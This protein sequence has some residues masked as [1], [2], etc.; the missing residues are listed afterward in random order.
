MKFFVDTGSVEDAK[1]AMATGYCD[2]VTT[3][4]SLISKG[5]SRPLEIIVKEITEIVHG[6]TSVEVIAEDAVKMI[7]EG[8]LYAS[9]ST[10]VV[11]KVPCT[12]EG[13]KACKAL[14]REGT[15][16]NVTLCFQPLQALVAAKCGAAYISPFIGRLDDIGHVGLQL[17]ED[18][19]CLYETY[20]FETE[21][22]AASIR[23]VEHLTRVA[24]A[25]SDVATIPYGVFSKV[26]SHP[27]TD[28]GLEVFLADW[29][30]SRPS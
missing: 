23:T 5:D 29:N 15:P 22:L 30:A 28:K 7:E 6:P 8:Q 24:L 11:V 2:G 1:K 16:V 14:S 26:L 20:G 3:N 17:I 13:L 9:W 25:G 27:L 21:I 19:R 10:H 18:I 12:Q 4:P